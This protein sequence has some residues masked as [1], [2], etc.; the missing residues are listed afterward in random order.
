MSI[1]SLFFS[2][3]YLN[4][5][6]LFIC[7]FLRFP[8]ERYIWQ[9]FCLKAPVLS[10]FLSWSIIRLEKLEANDFP[11]SSLCVAVWQL[12]VLSHIILAGSSH[13]ILLSRAEGFLTTA[14]SRPA[15]RNAARKVTT[16]TKGRRRTDRDDYDR[17]LLLDEEEQWT[18]WPTWALWVEARWLGCDQNEAPENPTG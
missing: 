6:S 13:C 8:A 14:R 7:Y 3:L 11:S 10:L 16:E 18:T 9:K 1:S 12:L 2:Y 17:E 5:S 4:Q 15:D